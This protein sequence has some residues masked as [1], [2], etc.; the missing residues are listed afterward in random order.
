[1]K[2][3]ISGF[4]VFDNN[5]INPSQ[6]VL[7]HLE[8]V[9]TIVLPVSFEASFQ[10]LK[11]KVMDVNPEFVICLGLASTRSNITPERLAMNLIEA[12]IPDNDGKQPIGKKIIPTG[13][14]GLFSSL[15]IKQMVKACNDVGVNSEISNTAGTYVCNY[16]MYQIIHLSRELN[17]KAGFIHLPP[18]EK[19][20]L[21]EQVKGLNAMI[22]SLRYNKYITTPMGSES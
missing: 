3:L 13:T 7:G 16:L 10:I 19:I 1:M 6:E 21:Q 14:D 8:N 2:V 12:R 9:E 22:L 20:N 17:F 15:P 11:K 4:E 18:F 5:K